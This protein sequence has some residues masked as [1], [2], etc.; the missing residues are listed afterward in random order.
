MVDNLDLYAEVSPISSMFDCI[1]FYTH[2]SQTNE[3]KLMSRRCGDRFFLFGKWNKVGL[4][5]GFRELS[6][7]QRHVP[8]VKIWWR[9]DVPEV[10]ENKIWHVCRSG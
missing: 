8:Y 9:N 10:F 7:T 4:F 3:Q 5:V 6:S 1:H 2:I